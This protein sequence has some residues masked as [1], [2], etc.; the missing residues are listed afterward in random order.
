V[1]RPPDAGA[2][3]L[4]RVIL[5]AGSSA[6]AVDGIGACGFGAWNQGTDMRGTP[7]GGQR[8]MPRQ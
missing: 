7:H 4:A 6:R 2:P 8:E 1:A 5:L 3:S